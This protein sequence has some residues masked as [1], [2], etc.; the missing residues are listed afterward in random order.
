MSFSLQWAPFYWL[1]S[2][3]QPQAL[4]SL[5][6]RCYLVSALMLQA[7]EPSM[8]PGPRSSQGNNPP[9]AKRSL[10]TV[11]LPPVEAGSALLKTSPFIQVNR[12]L[13]SFLDIP[14]SFL[15]NGTSG[16]NSRGRVP[17]LVLFPDWPWE[18]IQERSSYPAAIF[19]LLPGGF[20]NA[21]TNNLRSQQWS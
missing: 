10:L 5:R 13:L 2:P 6:A 14:V 8:G 3:R 19:S 20:V 16:G 1:Q 17:N 15:L 7:V 9:L 18:E 21:T 4:P 12:C 11:G